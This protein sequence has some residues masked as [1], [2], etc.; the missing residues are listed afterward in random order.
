MFQA[1]PLLA[2]LAAEAEGMQVGPGLLLLPLLNPVIVAEETATLDWLTGGNA[3]IGLGLGYRAEE[4][5]PYKRMMGRQVASDAFLRALARHDPS[6]I[7]SVYAARKEDVESFRALGAIAKRQGS[8]EESKSYYERAVALDPL[9]PDLRLD[10]ASV[11][12][13]TRDLNGALETID[14]HD[15]ARPLRDHRGA[16]RRGRLR[17]Q[18][19]GGLYDRDDDP[20]RWRH[21]AIVVSAAGAVRA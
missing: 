10:L 18:H 1:M 20:R 21:R 2:R 6:P 16:R 9:R 5:D 13:T 11:L 7:L 12:L 19:A 17:R 4:F 15:P 3:I 14:R 8:W